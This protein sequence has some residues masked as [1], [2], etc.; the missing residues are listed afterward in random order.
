MLRHVGD[1]GN[2]VTS[3]SSVTS[4][5]KLDF[6]AS[7]YPGPADVRDRAFVIHAGRD[8]FGANG[9]ESGLKTGNAGSSVTCGIIT[10]HVKDLEA[11]VEIMGVDNNPMGTVKLSQASPQSPVEFTGALEG[12]SEGLHGFHIHQIGRTGNGCKDAGGHYNPLGVS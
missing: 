8:D 5:S 11:E 9:D 10:E 3:S 7:L 4:I 1:L 2:I 6:H 12:V